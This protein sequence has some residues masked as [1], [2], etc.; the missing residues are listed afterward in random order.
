MPKKQTDKTVAEPV[1]V[2][3]C[4]DIGSNSILLS[5]SRPDRAA[6]LKELLYRGQT[7][8]LGAALREQ[9]SRL[10]PA[11]RR[12]SLETIQKFVREA[13]L[14]KADP[15]FMVGTQALRKAEDSG[16]FLEAIRSAAGLRAEVL[17]GEDEAS[18]NF[19]STCAF[20]PKINE[21]RVLD[22]G[23][24]STEIAYGRDAEPEKLA[25]YPLGCVALTEQFPN[26]E[27]VP[28]LNDYIADFLDKNLNGW[29][30]KELPLIGVSGTI[31]ALAA[32]FLDLSQYDSGKIHGLSIPR[33]W[34]TDF[35][36]RYALMTETEKKNLPCLS[37]GRAVV[38]SAGTAILL[39]MMDFF[40]NDSV[41]VSSFGLR[42]AVLWKH[43]YGNPS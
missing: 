29:D 19:F 33:E 17:S 30:K 25:S 39:G 9:H 8:R 6:G 12:K 13:R 5:V 3:A 37:P 18:L 38:L 28:M 35:H 24:G 14:L 42:H 16:S 31:T 10:D 32:I 7:T 20:L 22:I 15:I 41:T 27:D 4:I 34:I 43:F 1:E 26:G 40:G 21:K 11:N 23:G 36:K 2:A